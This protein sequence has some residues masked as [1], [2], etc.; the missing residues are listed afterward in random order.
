MR[1]ASPGLANSVSSKQI[2]AVQLHRLIVA[3]SP[4]F[5]ELATAVAEASG[6][7]EVEK[8]IGRRVMHRALNTSADTADSRF[9]ALKF[10]Q[11]LVSLPHWRAVSVGTPMTLTELVE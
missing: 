3:E 6:R 10:I 5:L 7:Q 2:Q 8:L 11:M 4:K 1:E 9:A